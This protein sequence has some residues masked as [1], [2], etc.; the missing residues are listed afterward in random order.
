VAEIQISREHGGPWG[1]VRSDEECD[2]TLPRNWI[3]GV[4]SHP[5]GKVRPSGSHL[6][7]TVMRG[8][9]V[10]HL[11]TVVKKEGGAQA[12]ERPQPT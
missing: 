11:P 9:D 10:Y 4:S 5:E 7:R 8:E 1:T 12:E 6:W 2:G 3:R